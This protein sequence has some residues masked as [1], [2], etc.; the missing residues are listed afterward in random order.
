MKTLTTKLLTTVGLGTA[1]LLGGCEMPPPESS[2]WG[3]RGTGMEGL[4][5]PD[6]LQDVADNNVVPDAIP[7]VPAVGPKASDIYKNV[8]VL[9]DLSVG[10][11]TRL[12]VAVTQ[13][14]SPEEGCNYCHVAGEGFE[15]DTLYT[16]KV[17]RVMI[18][19]TQNANENWD[20][21]VGGAGVTCYTCHRGKNVPEYVWN[22]NPGHKV[23]SG[24]KN[25]MQNVSLVAAGL[26]SLPVDPFTPYLL[27]DRNGRHAGTTALR[28]GGGVS[29]KESEWGYS[30]MMHFSDSLGVNCTYCHNSRAFFSWDESAPTRVRAWHGIRMVREMN[31]EY[32]E[33]TTD[34]L[35]PHRLG[36]L[37]DAQKVN[38][39]TCH[40]GA[41][42]PLLGAN[43]IKDYPN[44]AR[45]AAAEP[46][47]DLDEGMDMPESQGDVSADM[48]TG[49]DQ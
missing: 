35:P 47:A 39:E 31:N 40:Q 37:G 9:G 2:Q 21:H 29:M 49:G 30:L 44:L 26:S 36:A 18:Q 22:I 42:K 43:M 33:P 28:D 19:M 45:L 17:A 4:Y 7:A 12:M 32:V 48:T 27:D 14:V 15:A 16:K 13:W 46:E 10:E 3:Y 5:D 20:Q 41:Y 24:M 25:Q 11:F 38:C 34:W 1:L 6:R 8:Q 23:A